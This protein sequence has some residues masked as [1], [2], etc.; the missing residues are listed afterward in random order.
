MTTKKRLH[1]SASDCHFVIDIKIQDDEQEDNHTPVIIS[2]S[3]PQKWRGF[4][5]F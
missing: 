4:S 3:D 5:L 2:L 1:R